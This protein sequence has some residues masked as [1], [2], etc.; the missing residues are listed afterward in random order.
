M[1]KVLLVTVGSDVDWFRLARVIGD[2]PEV[3]A[4]EG[5]EADMVG[6][7]AAMRARADLLEELWAVLKSASAT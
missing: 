1:R 3:V 5:A 7:I 4:V 6:Q 2:L